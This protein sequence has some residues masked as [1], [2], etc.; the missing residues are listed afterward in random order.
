MSDAYPMTTAR[1]NFGNLIRRTAN[2]RERIAI[3]DHG[4]TA[5]ILINPVELAEIEEALEFA[6]YKL[7]Q[8]DGTAETV[9]HGDVRRIL[10]L[11][12]Q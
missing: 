10:G 12:P 5:A 7:R 4:H 8:I 1:A 11:P 3:T 2:D 6:Q 9:P